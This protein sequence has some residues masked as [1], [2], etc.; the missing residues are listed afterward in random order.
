MSESPEKLAALAQL[1]QLEEELAG[2]LR[3]LANWKEHDMNRSDG[4]GA[5]DRRH[6]ETGEWIKERVYEAQQAIAS[7]KAQ[8]AQ[9]S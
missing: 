6:E 7:L 8:I 4:S 3:D 1:A 5:Q 9:M 2:A